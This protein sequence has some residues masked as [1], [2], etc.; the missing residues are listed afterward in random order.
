MENAIIFICLHDD[1]SRKLNVNVAVQRMTA[2]RRNYKILDV[3][4]GVQTDGTDLIERL[5]QKIETE[6][7]DHILSDCPDSFMNAIGCQQ[8]R[9]LRFVDRLTI[10]NL[11]IWFSKDPFFNCAPHR[12]DLFDKDNW[13]EEA[14]KA[15]AD[16]L[17]QNNSIEPDREKWMRIGRGRKKKD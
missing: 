4:C 12:E 15:Y 17:K 13:I 3:I 5:Y 2:E 10:H 14:E 16:Y 7:V 9:A 1:Q 8:A 6:S 11:K